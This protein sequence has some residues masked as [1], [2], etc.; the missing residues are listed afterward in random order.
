MSRAKAALEGIQSGWLKLRIDKVF[1]LEEAAQAHQ[2]LE[3]RN[4]IGKVLLK[5]S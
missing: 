2:K 3:S 5:T 1:P 4:T